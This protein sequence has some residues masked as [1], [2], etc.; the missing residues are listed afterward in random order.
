MDLTGKRAV[1]TGAGGGIGRAIVAGL[2]QRGATVV[3][4]D[5]SAGAVGGETLRVVTD[6]TEEASVK[7]AVKKTIEVL[8]QVDV[9]VTAAGTL[10]SAPITEMTLEDWNAIFAVNVTGSFLAVKHLGPVMTER[11][12][13]VFL[14]SVTAFV[15]HVTTSAY[16]M[17]K[18]DVLSLARAISMEFSPRGI[19]VNTVCPGWVDAGFTDQVLA[20]SED[21]I[22]MRESAASVHL[23]GRMALPSEVADAVCF[24]VS[25]ESSFI[26]GSE[27]FVDGGFMVKR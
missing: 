22:M 5:Q 4:W 16:G 24:L 6:V 15:G 14:S 3:G 1:V 18:G 23:L 26:T 21:P 19:R 20:T 8:G 25:D 12:S 7:Q 10:R 11:G 27:L 2:A 17:T 9:L 13:I